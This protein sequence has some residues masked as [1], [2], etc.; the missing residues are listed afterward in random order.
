MGPPNASRCAAYWEQQSVLGPVGV[1]VPPSVLIA[2][3][4]AEI[5]PTN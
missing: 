3:Q 2:W 1:A 4:G 5:A